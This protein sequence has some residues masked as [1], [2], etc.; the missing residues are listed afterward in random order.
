MQVIFPAALDGVGD[1]LDACPTAALLP[2]MVALIEADAG[3][4]GVNSFPMRAAEAAM[5]AALADPPAASSRKTAQRVAAV[6]APWAGFPVFAW[7]TPDAIELGFSTLSP[8]VRSY[9]AHSDDPGALASSEGGWRRPLSLFRY[10]NGCTDLRVTPRVRLPWRDFAGA[11][12]AMLDT[13]AD[14]RAPLLG[15]LAE[16]AT[17]AA[18]VVAERGL[19]SSRQ[20]LTARA[21]LG[22]RGYLEARVAAAPTDAMVALLHRVAP[23]FAGAYGLGNAEVAAVAEAITGDWRTDLAAHVAPVEKQITGAVEGV[24]GLWLLSTP[25]ARDVTLQRG[26]AELFEGFAIGLRFAAAIGA[27]QS[28]PVSLEQI[29]AALALGEHTVAFADEA[30]PAFAVPAESHDRGPRMA[31]LDMTLEAIC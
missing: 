21:F 22:F 8:V 30:L 4:D 12:D 6:A 18:T 24:V 3:K 28:G 20:P 15:R 14:R 16:V 31:D 19:P 11:R 5:R 27:A 2:A 1:D 10:A 29:A 7:Q 17:L 25:L 9:L 23:L 13:I 26:W